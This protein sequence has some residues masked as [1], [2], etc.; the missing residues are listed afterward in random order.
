MLRVVI[1]YQPSRCQRH[2]ASVPSCYDELLAPAL[3]KE[4]TSRPDDEPPS[5]FGSWPRLYAA[6][7]IHLAFWIFIFYLFTERFHSPS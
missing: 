1:L 7:L 2:A 5:V 4:I 6:V 3:P